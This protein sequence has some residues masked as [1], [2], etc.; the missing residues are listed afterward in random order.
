M[1]KI[2]IEVGG[3][4]HTFCESC[5][6]CRDRECTIFFRGLDDDLKGNFY[7]CEECL[8]AEYSFEVEE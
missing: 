3:S 8:D 5:P 7:R 1:P 2:L 6:N 4:N